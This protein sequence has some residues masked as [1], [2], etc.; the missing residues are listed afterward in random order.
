MNTCDTCKWW[1]GQ[2]ICTSYGK[3]NPL[4]DVYA[5]CN[6]PM[7]NGDH[8]LQ[9]SRPDGTFR[10][11]GTMVAKAEVPNKWCVAN[12][13]ERESEHTIPLDQSSPSASD[14]HGLCFVTGPKFG[15]IHHA[16]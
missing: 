11:M 3:E 14:D 2:S 8:P 1:E 7:V 16:T 5:V 9:H 10:S 12:H 15:C 13:I 6:N 4:I